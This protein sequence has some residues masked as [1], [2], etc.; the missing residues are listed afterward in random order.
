MQQMK[1]TLTLVTLFITTN[2]LAQDFRLGSTFGYGAYTIATPIK[3]DVVTVGPGG[4]G[5][6]SGTAKTQNYIS[7]TSF[8]FI[9][10]YGSNRNWGVRLEP[11]F[12]SKGWLEKGRDIIPKKDL[13]KE[14]L[15]YFMLPVSGIYYIGENN[16]SFFAKGG[17]QIGFLKQARVINKEN[18][19]DIDSKHLHNTTDAGVHL[20]LGGRFRLSNHIDSYIEFE[21]PYSFSKVFKSAINKSTNTSVRGGVGLTYTLSHD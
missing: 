18:N 14:E 15:Q 8:G 10:E 1:I 7:G 4:H 19:I 20:G 5:T 11:R 13:K 2:L 16:A 21:V 3:P 12:E 6:S 9:A 17:F